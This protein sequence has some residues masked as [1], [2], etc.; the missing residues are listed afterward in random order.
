MVAVLLI[1]AVSVLLGFVLAR[2]SRLTQDVAEL[3]AVVY[4][5]A[6]ARP[7]AK[8]HKAQRLRSKPSPAPAPADDGEGCV[9]D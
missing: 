6:P 2:V 8:A 3:R 1:V 9:E 4:G 7:S 5:Y